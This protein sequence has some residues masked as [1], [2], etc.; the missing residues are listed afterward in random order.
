DCVAVGRRAEL[1][2]RQQDVELELAEKVTLG[3]GSSTN[4]YFDG[5]RRAQVCSGRATRHKSVTAKC[6]AVDPGT[7]EA[8]G[9]SSTI[10]PFRPCSVAGPGPSTSPCRGRPPR[11]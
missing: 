7:T 5:G 10:R 11:R 8:R 1:R 6:R 9:S 2:E 4:A 3:H